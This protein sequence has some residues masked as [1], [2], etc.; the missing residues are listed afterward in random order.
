MEVLNNNQSCEKGHGRT[1]SY[2]V[3]F[4]WE[5]ICVP[6]GQGLLYNLN[7]NRLMEGLGKGLLRQMSLLKCTFSSL[8]S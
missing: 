5:K 1:S 8:L 2:A 6:N 4:P 3:I 7:E